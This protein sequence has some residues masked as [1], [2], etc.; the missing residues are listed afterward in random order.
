M[1]NLIEIYE[2][3]RR[4]GYAE[5][6]QE[7]ERKRERLISRLWE[8]SFDVPVIARWAE[9]SEEEVRTVAM[10]EENQRLLERRAAEVKA[11]PAILKE[12]D[13]IEDSD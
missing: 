7:E 4:A 1:C 12:H 11:S 9:C 3:G 6:A 8:M 5:A 10:A 2:K 13:L